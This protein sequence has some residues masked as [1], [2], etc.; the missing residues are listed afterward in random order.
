MGALSFRTPDHHA[1]GV[2]AFAVVPMRPI[3]F[4]RRR[5]DWGMRTEA[6]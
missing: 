3:R 6:S 5:T 1:T 2:M 4:I